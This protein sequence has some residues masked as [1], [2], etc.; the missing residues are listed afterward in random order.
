MGTSQVTQQAKAT[1]RKQLFRQCAYLLL[2]YVFVVSIFLTW[3]L[4]EHDTSDMKST[5]K[6]INGLLLLGFLSM[7][8]LANKLF[9]S[10][11]EAA[12]KRTTV[13]WWLWL[14]AALSMWAA[15]QFTDSVLS[16]WPAVLMSF[17]CGAFSVVVLF[18]RSQH[19]VASNT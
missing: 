13:H 18:F 7:I 1:S 6:A 4:Y 17:I 10:S 14:I 12:K 9:P 3:Q 2:A 5:Y 16:M 19:G 15:K 8:V 11:D